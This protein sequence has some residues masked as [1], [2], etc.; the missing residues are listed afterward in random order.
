MLYTLDLIASQ[1]NN[2]NVAAEIHTQLFAAGNGI[3]KEL[4][5]QFD[6]H[7]K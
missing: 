7:F 3:Q 2:A 6:S 5:F 1:P 4:K